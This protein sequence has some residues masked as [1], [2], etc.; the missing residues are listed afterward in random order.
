ML[1][2]LRQLVEG[3]AKGRLKPDFGLFRKMIE[4]IDQVPEKVHH[5]K[6]DEYPS[7]ACACAAPRPCR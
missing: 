4:Y 3:I 1:N 6:E 5:P 2:G 7:P